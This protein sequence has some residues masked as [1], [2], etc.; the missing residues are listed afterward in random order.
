MALYVATTSFA[1]PRPGLETED[2]HVV[3]VFVE[4][5]AYRLP[6]KAAKGLPL[7]RVDVGKRRDVEVVEQATAAPGEKRIRKTDG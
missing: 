6:V 4:G 5:Q 1:V 2:G 3:R 7:E